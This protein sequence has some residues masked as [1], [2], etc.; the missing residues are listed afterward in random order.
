M[1]IKTKTFFMAFNIILSAAEL[2]SDVFLTVSYC[3]NG[4]KLCCIITGALITVHL[5]LGFLGLPCLFVTWLQESLDAI[6]D[7]IELK[8][9]L[10]ETRGILAS[11]QS[12]PQLLIAGSF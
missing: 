1:A 4:N 2:M 5:L 12:A 10:K 8:N 3:V 9:E 11:F 6:D 7:D